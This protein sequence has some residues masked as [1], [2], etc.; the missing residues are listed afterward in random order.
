[1]KTKTIQLYEFKEFSEEIKKKVIKKLCCIN[2]DY[3]WWEFV[4]DDFCNLAKTSGIKVNLKKTFFTGFYHQGQ[5]SA[6]TAD[7]DTSELIQ[8]VYDKAWKE[9]A[10]DLEFNFPEITNAILRIR[11]L[12]I[13]NTI[14]FGACV[15]PTNR[16]TAINT[17]FDSTKYR[18]CKCQNPINVDK[19][20][21]ETEEFVSSVCEELNH[22]LFKTLRDEFD[23]LTSKEA[24]SETTNANQYYFTEKGKLVD[25]D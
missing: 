6:F 5:G 13:N 11:K 2:V 1:M 16:E 14:E 9:Y 8:C 21:E 3:G 15:K 4:Y 12:I 19:A 25:C 24:I 10:P 17:D 7:I 20:I 22:F 23:H 18:A